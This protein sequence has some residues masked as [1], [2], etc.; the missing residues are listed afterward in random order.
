MLRSEVSPAGPGSRTAC[1]GLAHCALFYRGSG[2][3]ARATA[4]F[5]Q[6]GLAAGEPVL[7]AVRPSQATI[8]REALD[9]GGRSATFLDM[10]Q[11]G[12]N[13]GRIIPAVLDWLRQIGARPCRVVGEPVWPGR[14]ERELVESARQE[15]LVNL[16]L[17]DY[18][19]AVLCPYDAT[20][21][22]PSVLADAR[23]THPHL[24]DHRGTLE[25]HQYR[26]PIEVWRAHDFTLPVRP[27][28]AAVTPIDGDLGVVRDFV[29][30]EANRRGLGEDRCTDLVLGVSE[31]ATN[32]LLHGS[33]PR[34][35][36][37]WRD[38]DRVV[39]E[40]SDGGWLEDPLSGRRRPDAASDRGR[41]L[42]LINELCD[43]VELRP[44][45]RGTTLRLHMDLAS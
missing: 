13:P 6:A 7:V 22:H 31:A 42:W 12:R 40:I 3:F 35:L 33:A 38:G 25:S 45:L 15:A 37:V 24:A 26:D 27:D 34:E 4:D 39:C 41:G 28:S 5:V 9:D 21:L 20:A 19:V 10:R 17:E 2:E 11:L 23:R 8:L 32:A 14:G 30:D 43:L 36:G 16:A 1:T 29:K 18:P 44:G